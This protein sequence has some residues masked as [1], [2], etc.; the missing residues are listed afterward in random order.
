[1]AQPPEA[2]G[3]SHVGVWGKK[4]PSRGTAS[5][6]ALRLEGVLCVSGTARR[7]VWLKWSE[8]ARGKGWDKRAEREGARCFRALWAPVIS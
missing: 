2:G 7:A 6:K 4:I 1:M 3:A 5:A 8:Q